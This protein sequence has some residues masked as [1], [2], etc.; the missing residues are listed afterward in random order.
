MSSQIVRKIGVWLLAL[1]LLAAGCDKT[2]RVISPDSAIDPTLVPHPIIVQGIESNGAYTDP[3]T[4]SVQTYRGE[5]YSATINGEPYELGSVFARDG[6]H[7][8]AIR[9]ISSESGLSLTKILSISVSIATPNVPQ[10]DGVQN[11]QTSTEGL[12]PT[13]AP[14]TNITYEALLDGLPYTL[15][16][17]ITTNGAHTLTVVAKRNSTTKSASRTISFTIDIPKVD[18]TPPDAPIVSGVLEGGIYG[19]TVT[20]TAIGDNVTATIDGERYSLGT[21]FNANGDHTLVVTA[22]K[23]TNR[24][25]AST[26]IHFT[27]DTLPPVSPVVSGVS[28]GA[29]YTNGVTITATGSNLTATIDGVSYTL[30][31]N[32]NA[33]GDHA[34]V[35]TAKKS[36]TG[37]TSST[38]IQFTLDTVFPN[39]PVVSG[40][41]EG[42]TYSG[43]V[44]I[45]ATGQNLTAKIDG[46]NYT[47]GTLY[48]IEGSHT[49]VVTATKSSNGL[50]SSATVHFTIAIPPTAPTVSGVTEGTAYSGAVTITATGSNLAAT[51]DG[52]A[53]TL[54]TPYDSNGSHTLIVTTTKSN[55]LSASKTI[56]FT[57]NIPVLDLTPPPTPT[58]SGV[59]E[60]NL[61]AS[62][63]TIT[64]T[65]ENLSAT[66]DGISYTLGTVYSANGDHTLIVTTTKLSNGMTASKTVHFSID[67]VPPAQPTVSGVTEGALYGN[68]VIITATGQNLAATIDGS[69]YT[70]GT[71]YSVHGD[72]TL[73]V[74]T[75]KSGNG[76][77]TSATVHFSIDALP[78]AQP[79]VSGVTEGT[80]YSAAV[81][82]TATGAALTATIDGASYTLGSG[83]STEGSHT[84]VVTSTKSSNGL[85][86]TA[87]VHFTIAIPPTAPVVSGVSEGS[88]YNS[89]VTITAASQSGVVNSATIDGGSYP[90]GS[91]YAVN[92]SH[93]LVV[94]ATKSNGLTASTTVHF[95]IDAVPPN[96]PLIDG[97]DEGGVYDA[98][99]TISNANPESGVA[100]S[101]TIDGAAFTLGTSYAVNGSHTLIVT[102]TKT[103]NN[104]SASTTIHFTIDSLP[105]AAPVVSGVSE[106][107][108]YT[109]A[110]TINA[111]AQ[112]NVVYSAT[113]DGEFYNLGGSYSQNGEH[114]LVVTATKTTN[115]LTSST[116]IHFTISLTS[117]G[118]PIVQGVDEGGIYGQA[119]TIIVVSE[120]GIRV[121][122]VSKE[123]VY[124][125]TIDGS[126]Y[127]LGSSYAT[128][129]SHTI[130]VTKSEGGF[131]TSTTVHFTIDT[132]PPSVPDVLANGATA[133]N[134]ATYLKATGVIFTVTSQT[135]VAFKAAI[136]S[137]NYVLGVKYSKVGN[138]HN[139]VVTATKT[140]TGLTSTKTVPFK[141][142]VN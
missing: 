98:A 92:G 124:S 99:I 16:T 32:Y 79:T 75:T 77:T 8:I 141:V 63:V 48:S 11:G 24:M 130:V 14:Q 122:A 45:S 115:G 112:S 113:I 12:S 134:N 22:T 53:Y 108:T 31:T 120:S 136:D 46:A 129:G 13:V 116:T 101:A 139:L 123:P 30:G 38:T 140:S 65:G 91:S 25:T 2:F 36:T 35:V 89:A 106:G 29:I 61:Y 110:V 100:Y 57:I 33:N 55:G 90:L 117:D 84:L 133:I 59:T 73:V 62:G 28:E 19:N 132:V 20:I 126:F 105:P 52:A 70:L 64:A 121:A 9:A 27:V 47:L 80:T 71:T 82:I 93:T 4:I 95:T 21:V 1:G 72:H 54:G 66:I 85:T 96:Q 87:T 15:G 26:T 56:H 6:A 137:K 67:S 119:V 7:S 78:P 74:T 102:A 44:T 86:A 109:S 49:L 68:S 58:V 83:Y 5:E 69:A 34:L 127:E 43:G 17:L 23:S 88:T 104:V 39:Q 10:I 118:S 142:K 76:L 103:S 94:T 40:I 81:T 138:N 135:G 128:N 18:I 60:S 51:I 131:E 125:A 111:S 3:V 97:V 114:T 107:Q 42:V 37:L 50:T 41:T